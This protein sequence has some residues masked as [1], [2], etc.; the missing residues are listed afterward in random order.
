[1]NSTSRYYVSMATKVEERTS[2]ICSP[3]VYSCLYLYI[4]AVN[5]T[6]RYY[7]SM[8]TKVEE[9]TSHIALLSLFQTLGFIVGPGLQVINYYLKLIIKGESNVVLRNVPKIV[10]RK[11]IFS[12]Q[13]M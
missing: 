9:R 13:R 10:F 8:A 3:S 4:S 12:T 7:V 2:H 1:M 5:S 6:S 11:K